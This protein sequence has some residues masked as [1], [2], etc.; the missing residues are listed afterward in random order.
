MPYQFLKQS[1]LPLVCFSG[2]I[3]GEASLAS[4]PSTATV[5]SL[6]AGDIACYVELIDDKNKVSTQY[7]DFKIC[8]QDLVGK[9]VKLTYKS[10]NVQAASCQGNPKC[11]A[12]ERV[13]LIVKAQVV[14]QLS[15]R[16]LAWKKYYKSCGVGFSQSEVEFARKWGQVFE[17][18]W[19]KYGRGPKA[20]G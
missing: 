8:E 15:D 4:Q 13:Q 7:A 5:Q 17:A 3:Y 9:R 12:T 20:C 10:A 19:R 2:L 1:V 6:T 16:D 14:K 11:T 18:E